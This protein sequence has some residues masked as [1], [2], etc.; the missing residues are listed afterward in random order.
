M[1]QADGTLRQQSLEFA[2]VPNNTPPG[3]L[4]NEGIWLE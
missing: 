2:A 3:K 1:R 4:D